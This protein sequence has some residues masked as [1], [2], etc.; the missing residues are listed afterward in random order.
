MTTLA[1][2]LFVCLV[3]AHMLGDFVLQTRRLVAFKDRCSVLARH[4]ATVAVVS[5]LLCGVWHRWEIPLLIFASHMVIDTIKI[6]TGARSAGGFVADQLAHL[7]AALGAAAL[8]ANAGAIPAIYWLKIFGHDYLKTLA[9]VA[10]GVAAVRAGGFLIALAV[11]PYLAQ[12]EG[13]TASPGRQEDPAPPP[14]VGLAGG[15]QLIGQLERS[16]VFLFILMEQPAAIGFLITAKSIFR[17]GEIR[18]S[19]QRMMAEYI[20]VGTL[21]SFAYGTLIAYLTR[22]IVDQL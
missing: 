10:G 1:F 19:R 21:M 13:S 17:F 15:G 18:E 11:Q 14:V 5:Y 2:H 3:A 12:I 16:L 20:I 4:A 9:I 22:V 6:R 8:V 7:G